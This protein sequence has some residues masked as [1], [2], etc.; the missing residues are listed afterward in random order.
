MNTIHTADLCARLDSM[1]A[2]CD[3]LEQSQEDPA[4]YHQLV[5]RIRAE[6]NALRETLCE[7][8]LSP[9]PTELTASSRNRAD[10]N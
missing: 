2:L 1:K 6:A 7:E 4:R 8:A 10:A 5:E 3:R 9:E